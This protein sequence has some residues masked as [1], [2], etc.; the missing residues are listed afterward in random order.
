MDNVD[1]VYG[2]EPPPTSE[3]RMIIQG[4][5]PREAESRARVA[6]TEIIDS[7]NLPVWSAR[8]RL[9]R[10]DDREVI[11]P[12]VSQV[13]ADVN[14]WFVRVQVEAPTASQSVDRL[15]ER[16]RARIGWIE[17]QRE[18]QWSSPHDIAAH[19]WDEEIAPAWRPS[20]LS[21]LPGE[22]RIVRHKTCSIQAT[23]VDQ[24][25]LDMNLLDQ[26]FTLFTEAGSKQDS[27]LYR[28]GSTG[29]RLAQVSSRG[30]R[31]LRPFRLPLTI[32][33]QPAAL[34]SVPLA[35]D[36]LNRTGLPFL[37]FL[38][39][40]SGH[41]RVLYRRYDGHYGLLSA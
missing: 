8:V 36:R 15:A 25:A 9:T 13:N 38:D 41:S 27:V 10:Y 34:V 1:V 28:S 18:A 31:P 6:I 14:G 30:P 35:V 39:T 22:R 16:L 12:V 33:P 7:C 40:E 26:D 37:F 17:R 21:R 24:A 3:L 32:S 29:Y 19:A 11:D 2:L 23:T 5:V 4:A 20:Y